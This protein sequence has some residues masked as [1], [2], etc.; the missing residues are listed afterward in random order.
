MVP[1]PTSA[2]SRHGSRNWSRTS[3]ASPPRRRLIRP[4]PRPPASTPSA[5]TPATPAS[6]PDLG[7]IEARLK[8]LEDKPAP[9][10]APAAPPPADAALLSRVNTIADQ[11]DGLGKKLAE[12]QTQAE[13]AQASAQAAQAR[14][15]VALTRAAATVALDNGKPLGT[16]AHAPPALTRFAT[17]APPTEASLRLSYDA[18]A[19]KAQDASVPPTAGKKFGARMLTRIESLVTVS[20]GDHVL[21]GPPAATILAAAHERL[22][23]GDLAG[24]VTA[25]DGLDPAAK[26]AM[27]AWT[28]RAKALLDAR[29][30]LQSDQLGA[31]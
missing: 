2:R 9:A 7:P 21:V 20:Q 31:P 3:R 19:Q 24:A 28:D 12:A 4:G 29:A 25:L 27:A 18:A 10:P 22:Q 15:T 26:A 6:A 17:E 5:S 8:A 1:R 13:A 14:A 16:I 30:A 11:L 23:A